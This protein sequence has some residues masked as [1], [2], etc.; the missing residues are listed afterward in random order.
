MMDGKSIQVAIYGSSLFL[1][2]VTTLLLQEERFQ[3]IFFAEAT[4]VST[5]LHHNPAL[6]LYQEDAPPTDIPVLL[7]AGLVVAEVTPHKNQLTI[8]QYQSPQQCVDVGNISD[9]Q[10][11]ITPLFNSV[12]SE[13]VL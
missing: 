6:L 9:F 11:K 7:A 8:F 4:A 1:T 13:S 5:I 3:P 10:T 2:A 12:S